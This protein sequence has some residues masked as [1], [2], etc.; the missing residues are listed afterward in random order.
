MKKSVIPFIS[1][2]AAASVFC[3]S[4]CGT[5]N[6]NLS[7]T[8]TNSNLLGSPAETTSLPYNE[9]KDSGLLAMASSANS[10]AY[11]FSEQTYS[12]LGGSGNFA[13]SP[14]S[15]YMA[16]SVAAECTAG[17]T[18]D[19]ILSALGVSYEALETNFTKLYRSLIFEDYDEGRLTGKLNLTNS[20]WLNSGIEELNVKENC[21]SSLS[22]NFFC[23]SY[24]AD[25]A[26]YNKQ[27]NQAL[28]EFIK[29]RT[30]NMIDKNYEISQ[31]V[32][33]ILMNTLYLKDIW[34]RNG[35]PLNFTNE[36]YGFTSSS[37]DVKSVKLLNGDYSL[38]R[39]YEYETFTHY[40]ISTCNGHRLKFILPKDG[41][42]VSD[43][44][45]AENIEKIN[46][47]SD[48][49]ALDRE[50]LIRYHTHCQFP[51][52]SASF[53]RDVKG[54]LQTYFN[55]KSIF[56]ADTSDFS[57][58]SDMKNYCSQVR[59]TANLKVNKHGIEGAAVT[60][61]DVCG[62]AGPDEYTDVYVDFV[63]DR[64]FGYVITDSSNTVVFAGVVNA[65]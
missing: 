8:E 45:T 30:N 26:N 28:T 44:F 19:E 33:F 38:G 21:I 37:G 18:R 48:Y 36:Y 32:S 7:G 63:V 60:I 15:V 13:V 17:Q 1:V 50:N 6:S 23:Y 27:A 5:D 39:A 59:H 40:Y 12:A 11:D 25:F 3:L 62:S 4:A 65:I 9:R 10:F 14:V 57:S 41:Y 24:S 29:E 56:N 42:S 2:L 46:T 61:M 43:V 54:V 55:I 35:Y 34:K 20:I 53:D 16:L 31:E 22:N 47:I 64:A 58:I 51:E 49:N 52:F